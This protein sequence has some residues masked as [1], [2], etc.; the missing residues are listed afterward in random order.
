MLR[1]YWWC[2]EGVLVVCCWYRKGRMHMDAL[3]QESDDSKWKNMTPR[4]RM[5]IKKMQKADE[6]AERLK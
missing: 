5:R 1:V 3:K 2:V 6:E 4:E